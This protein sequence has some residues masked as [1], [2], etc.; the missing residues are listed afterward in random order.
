M[1]FS[2]ESISLEIDDFNDDKNIANFN[3]NSDDEDGV[4]GGG[5]R[6]ANFGPGIEML[7]N[8]KK[9][10]GGGGGG[11][12]SSGG[13]VNLDD[14]EADLN[15]LTSTPSISKKDAMDTAFGSAFKP[16]DDISEQNTSEPIKLSFSDEPSTPLAKTVS[17]RTNEDET[18]DGYK[19][20]NDIPVNPDLNVRKE[21]RLTKEEELREKFKYLKKLEHL[22]DKKRVRLS[23]EYSMESSLEEMRGEYE[24]IMAEKEKQNSMKFQGKIMMAIVTGLEYLNNKFDPFDLK[25]DGWAESVNENI[26]DYDEIFAELHEK[27]KSKGKMAP[28]LK[29]LFQLGGSAVM[30]HMT[31]TM[32]K[33]AMPGMEDIM[34][35]NPEL[36]QQ[37]TQ[38]AVN[39]MGQNNPGFGGFMNGIMGGGNPQQSMSPM[40]SPPAPRQP[41]YDDL[42][43][44]APNPTATRPDVG[45][46]RS[47]PNFKDAEDMD[48]R[49]GN[50]NEPP[51]DRRNIQMNMP[52][53][54]NETQ[55]TTR[56]PEMRGPRDID[57]LLSGIKPRAP[58]QP[59]RPPM[60]TPPQVEQNTKV[61]DMG[62]AGS[63]ISV[64]DLDAMSRDGDNFPRKSRRKRSEKN[65][66]SLHL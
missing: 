52:P 59:I 30:L 58:N 44:Y 45:M 5:S 57:D 41:N 33:S 36:M 43:S 24:Y 60:P 47:V 40:G 25:L 22:R 11:M 62:G 10:A 61:V 28:E 3:L 53:K 37:F 15:N 19:N 64:D 39:S 8:D 18:W 49:F 31:N 23:K 20:F 32:F 42:P 2:P 50:Y 65:T 21:P 51:L 1:S 29:L 63:V 9:K 17:Q 4:R 27:Y 6:S 14:I 54:V 55:P 56:R 35:Q 66:V 48:A 26:D 7:M 34:R 38:A 46:S 12:G 13:S 16:Y